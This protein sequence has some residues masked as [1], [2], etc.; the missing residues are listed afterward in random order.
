[1]RRRD[2]IFGVAGT[3]AWPVAARAASES[4]VIGFLG[5]ATADGLRQP[6]AAYHDGLKQLG[7]AEGRNV[8]IEYRWANNHYDQLPALAESLVKLK[9]AVILASGGPVSSLAAKHATSKIPIVFPAVSYPVELG[10]VASLSRPGGNLT[11]IDAFPAELDA[12]RL[13]LL[14][15]LVP[16]AKLIGVLINANRP[17]AERQIRDIEAA[18]QRLGQ[19]LSILR[20]KTE[21]DFAPAFETLTAQ[22]AG[23]LLV[24]ADPF[25]HS[26]REK[27]VALAAAH[28]IPAIYQWREFVVAGGLMSYGARLETAYRQAGVYTAR[29]L[30]GERPADLPVEQPTNIELVINL[31]AAKTLGLTLPQE[32]IARAD[33]LIE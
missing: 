15:E 1:M 19:D 11:G 4:P 13:E 7:Y 21:Q 26:R 33:E 16:S 9:V 27:V 8:T 31:K 32:I 28:A 24:P 22:R 30:K 5:S 3:T 29:I 12:K 17:F 20:V 14:H 6:I 23:G 25:L 18:G 2:F 10:L